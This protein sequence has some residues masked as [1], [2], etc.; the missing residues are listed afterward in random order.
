M[1]KEFAVIVHYCTIGGA[2]NATIV[3]L[4]RVRI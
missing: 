3:D 2:G 4:N 1:Q